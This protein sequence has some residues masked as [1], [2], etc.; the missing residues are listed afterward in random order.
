MSLVGLVGLHTGGVSGELVGLSG[1]SR[2]RELAEL[3][4]LEGLAV[5]VVSGI[6]S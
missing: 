6:S 1:V 4:G 3:V 5:N 2:D